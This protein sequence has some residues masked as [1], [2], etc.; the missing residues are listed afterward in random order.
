MT[1]HT[2]VAGY[3]H[4]DI[5]TRIQT[6]TYIQKQTPTYRHPHTDKQTDTHDIQTDTVAYRGWLPEAKSVIWCPHRFQLSILLFIQCPLIRNV[7][8]MLVVIALPAHPHHTCTPQYTQTHTHTRAR[9]HLPC[10]ILLRLMKKPAPMM[11]SEK[12]IWASMLEIW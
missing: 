6:P 9:A 2:Q 10:I 11:N 8:W 7:W 12:I 1:T 5:D 4:P 3:R